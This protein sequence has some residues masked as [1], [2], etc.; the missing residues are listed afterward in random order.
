MT[1]SMLKLAFVFVCTS[2]A[3]HARRKRASIGQLLSSLDAWKQRSHRFAR[4]ESTHGVFA[5]FAK[6]LLAHDVASAFHPS[7]AGIHM[8]QH[9]PTQLG[10][11][12]W[13]SNLA[14]KINVASNVDS[15]LQE[16]EINSRARETFEFV[17]KDISRILRVEPHW[18]HYSSNLKLVDPSGE[19]LG[20][21]KITN[22]LC[23][24][25]KFIGIFVASED[26]N[27]HTSF[28]EDSGPRMSAQG[29]ILVRGRGLPRPLPGSFSLKVDG[30]CKINFN[31]QGK[32]SD[33]LVDSW[34][35]NG[36]PIELPVL[37]SDA[38]NLSP[39][40]YLSLLMWTRKA[41]F[42]F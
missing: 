15:N 5:S 16:A 18:K 41:I 31:E 19:R 28:I 38:N 32:V 25:R 4:A 42:G 17:K 29:E 2:C 8:F 7:G 13:L 30:S 11:N 36:R 40:D 10:T 27:I 24:V 6:L 12:P 35:F 37:Q 20:L 34:R 22:L 39:K 33:V 3:G 26:V 14:M 1:L 9:C 23:I 21:P